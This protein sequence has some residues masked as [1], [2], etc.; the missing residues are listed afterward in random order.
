MKDRGH[1]IPLSSLVL[2]R[3]LARGRK[4]ET[5]GGI[6]NGL[7]PL[8]GRARS[9]ADVLHDIR[10]HLERFQEDGLVE[11]VSSRGSAVS[12]T[13]AG[14]EEACAFLGLDRV[15][16][17]ITWA[18]VRDTY[19]F[20]RAMGIEPSYLKKRGL[21]GARAVVLAQLLDLPWRP[22]STL[23]S[24]LDGYLAR[25]FE[26]GSAPRH[27]LRPALVAR[28]VEPEPEEAAAAPQAEAFDLEAF[29]REV[30]SA[31]A[32]C[33]SGWF[34]EDKVF[35]SHVWE[36]YESQPGNR[37]RDVDAFKRRLVEAHRANLLT[38][39]RAD[40]VEAMDPQDVAA[41]ETRYLNATFHFVRSRRTE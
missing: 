21:D 39:V 20:A 33:P 37:V 3:L 19:L 18:T 31:A 38:L 4:G 22:S 14:R 13:P 27:A 17:R 6:R 16:A 24:V 32:A 35:I 36:R 25:S 40:L 11:Q 5:P 1:R 12:L 23:T 9:K 30:L 10:G 7:Q 28:A 8:A 29:A 26:L 41:S 15:P 34:G 2:A